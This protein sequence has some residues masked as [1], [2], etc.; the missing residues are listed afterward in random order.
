[1]NTPLTCLGWNTEFQQS[2]D[3]T[4][5]D[6]GIP[7]RVIRGNNSKYVIHTG[8]EECLAL[9]AGNLLS[10]HK[11]PSELLTV[12]DWVIADEI[13]NHHEYMIRSILPRKTLFQRQIAGNQSKN[14]L[15]AA[16][17]DYLFIITGLD[18]NFNIHR[19][20]RHLSLAWDSGAQPVVILNKSDLIEDA[21]TIIS[22]VKKVAINVPIFA[23]SA[24]ESVNLT[25]ID[26]Y[27]RDGKTIAMSGSSGVGKSTLINA[28]LGEERLKTQPIRSADGQG[29]H[30]T[31]WRELILIE[32]KGSLIDLPGVRELQLTSESKGVQKTFSDIEAIA[33]QCRFRNCSH[34]EEPGCAVQEAITNG[35]LDMD[36]FHQ[37]LKLNLE[38]AVSKTKQAYRK[39]NQDSKQHKRQ[40]KEEFF[41]EIAIRRRKNTKTNRKFNNDGL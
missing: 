17:I 16:N 28:I 38:A 32:G 8:E 36:R 14:Q 41:K 7:A 22:E 5:N 19:I 4:S 6:T 1:M 12:G 29:R 40:E 27:L 33:R 11:S 31:T 24:T 35:T 21:E 23:I 30:T 20:Q 37:F 26:E 13:P 2:F 39:K 3:K 25:F 15:V 34:D 18:D 10:G 9:L